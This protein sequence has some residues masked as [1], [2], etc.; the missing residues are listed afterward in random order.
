MNPL[1]ENSYDECLCSL[2]FK[3]HLTT[4][5]PNKQAK[6][7]S[8]WK[9]T[10]NEQKM[11]P[12]LKEFFF[13]INSLPWDQSTQEKEEEIFACVVEYQAQGSFQD[14]YYSCVF[15]LCGPIRKPWVFAGQEEVENTSSS[16][17]SK[18]TGGWA[19]WMNHTMVVSSGRPWNWIP[20]CFTPGSASI[21]DRHPQFAT[22]GRRGTL[23]PQAWGSLWPQPANCC[24]EGWQNVTHLLT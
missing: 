10:V 7:T 21:T 24:F 22:A 16:T 11:K 12:C 14:K 19:C 5:A 6:L 23:H 1:G 17:P 15:I 18:H 2:S 9:S 4:A 20:A 3:V 8:D 13:F